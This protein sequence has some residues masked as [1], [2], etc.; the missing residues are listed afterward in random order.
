M[1]LLKNEKFES[2]YVKKGLKVGPG[3]REFFRQVKS[4]VSSNSRIKIH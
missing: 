4:E 1:L 2:V 3:L